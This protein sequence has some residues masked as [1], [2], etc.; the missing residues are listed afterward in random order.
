M[1]KKRFDRI[2]IIDDDAGSAYLAR[3]T[4][5]DM[6][7]AE[8]VVV[9][10]TA[11]QALVFIQQ[12]CMNPHAAPRDCPDLILLDINMPV[13]DGYEFLD[14]LRKLG[15]HHLINS[16]VVVLTSSSYSKDQQKM[17]SYGV[18]GYITKPI[19]QEEIMTLV[20]KSR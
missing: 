1:E 8:E 17:L 10:N 5:E 9:L 18:R 4:L 14:A 16:V 15:Q 19:T 12:H 11:Q 3:F 13:M 2:L 6:A 7:I 20:A